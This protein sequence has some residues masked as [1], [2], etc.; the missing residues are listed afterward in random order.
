V[1]YESR[2]LNNLKSY[3]F[4]EY[5]LWYKLFPSRF[6]SPDDV[7]IGEMACSTS[8]VKPALYAINI[9]WEGHLLPFKS[10]TQEKNYP[11]YLVDTD[12]LPRY[13]NAAPAKNRWGGTVYPQ[14][15]LTSA[16]GWDSR[17]EYGEV[18]IGEKR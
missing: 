8:K 10:V 1:D 4:T 17:G 15:P 11:H 13:N 16:S 14:L 2:I 9:P 6:C 3:Q 7:V 5:H 12:I 18:K